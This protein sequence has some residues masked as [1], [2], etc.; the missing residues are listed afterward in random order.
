MPVQTITKAHIDALPASERRTLLV[1]LKKQRELR[2]RAPYLFYKP[3]DGWQMEM[4]KHPARIRLAHCG[5]RTGKSYGVIGDVVQQMY[6]VHPYHKEHDAK[7]YMR[8]RV[9]CEDEEHGIDEWVKTLKQFIPADDIQHDYI[10]GKSKTRKLTLNEKKFGPQHYFEFMT[11]SQEVRQFESVEREIVVFD[12]VPPRQIYTACLTR[13][14]A[15]GGTMLIGATPATN[16][17]DPGFFR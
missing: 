15:G 11:Y 9:V 1:K 5:N 14:M 8:I 13:I 3:Y 6:K 10:P 4:Y 17:L 12:E 16:T 2:Q 7:P